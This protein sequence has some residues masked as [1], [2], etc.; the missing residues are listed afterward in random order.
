MMTRTGP[1]YLCLLINV[2]AWS[3]VSKVTTRRHWL[4]GISS[5]TTAL[6][7]TTTKPT[8]SHSIYKDSKSGILFPDPGEISSAIPNDWSD[9]ENPFLEDSSIFSRLDPTP[10]SVFYA[11]TRFV[12]HVDDS[13]VKILTDFISSNVVTDGDYV[14][15]LC[16]SWTSHLDTSKLRL[17]R[18][19]GLGMNAIELAANPS[20][21]DWTVSDLNQNSR[22]PY[23]DESFSL[24]LCQLSIDYLTRPLEVLREVGR[25]LKPGGA[26]YIFFSNRLFIQKAVALWT[27]ADDIDHAYTVASY[28]HFSGGNFV[29]IK[30]YD[31]SNRKASKIVGDPVYVVSAIKS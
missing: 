4:R 15:D 9:V 16:S 26:I 24:V 11:E 2:H 25:V 17:K 31:L 28:L 5:L 21:T 10:D 6:I 22:L 30:A 13:A 14:L 3:D 12:E 1:Y 29:N 19:S 8:P 20:L 27:G 23:D 7:C 18:V